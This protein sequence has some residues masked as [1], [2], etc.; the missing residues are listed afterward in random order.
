MPINFVHPDTLH[1]GEIYHYIE[2][3]NDSSEPPPIHVTL[4]AYDNC[5]ALVIVAN[6]KGRKWRC[7]RERLLADQGA[8]KRQFQDEG[9]VTCYQPNDKLK[10][11]IELCEGISPGKL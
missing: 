11:A 9:F 3:I 5:P 4:L 7:P 10:Y 1:E 8:E 6:Q 2:Q